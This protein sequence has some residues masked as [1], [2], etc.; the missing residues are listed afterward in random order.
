MMGEEENLCELIQDL[1]R[2]VPWKVGGEET[3]KY[4]NGVVSGFIG[5]PPSLPVVSTHNYCPILAGTG[6]GVR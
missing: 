1:T 2:K 5:C 4:H 3:L 6:F